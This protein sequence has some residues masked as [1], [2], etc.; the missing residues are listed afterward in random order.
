MPLFHVSDPADPRLAPYT[1]IREKDLTS[2]HG[3]R[4]IVEGKVTLETLLRRGRF[5]VESLFLCETRLGPLADILAHVPANVPLYVAP[6]DVMDAVAGF[7]I[8]RGV[9]A[10]GLKGDTTADAARVLSQLAQESPL[11]STLLLL[12]DLSNHDNVGA[13]FRN[14]AAF[15][16]DAVLLDGQCCDP[17]YR[18]A[19]RVSS[20]A[21]LWLPYAQGGTALDMV[22]AAKAAGYDVW[23]M[24]PRADA[25]LLTAL[26]VPEK[27][28][29]LLG[30]EG[31]GLPDDVIAACT[32][33][34]IAMSDGFDSVNV[35]TAGAI[36]LSHAFGART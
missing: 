26:P 24:T 30:A 33:V 7:P 23:A 20:G 14:A 19:I 2:G 22:N 11:P 32:P 21:S 31:P 13:C 8:H 9:L 28:A 35:A 1:S 18:K 29:I 17:L 34:R 4:F 3:G 25:A 27:L 36:A 6:Q 10:C 12:S 15:G 5:A 16:A